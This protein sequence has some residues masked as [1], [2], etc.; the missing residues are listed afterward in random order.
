MHHFQVLRKAMYI[1]WTCFNVN[2]PLYSWRFYPTHN[3]IYSTTLHNV[4]EQT[5]S[6]SWWFLKSW[7]SHRT[8]TVRDGEGRYQ[9]RLKSPHVICGWHLFP[10]RQHVSGNTQVFLCRHWN[11]AWR[12]IILRTAFSYGLKNFVQR[13]L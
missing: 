9:K 5:S 3:I 2:S 1:L 12:W 7:K 4:G 8:D 13:L 10:I 6:V 11:F